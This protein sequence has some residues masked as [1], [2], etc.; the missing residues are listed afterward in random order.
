MRSGNGRHRRPRQAPALFVTA[1]VTGAGLALPLFAAGGAQAADGATWDRVAECESGGLWSANSGN[2]YY[3]GLQLTM[4]MWE[5]YGGKV[6][7]ARPDLASRGQQIEVAEKI[8]ADQGP[9]A[10]PSCS[11][12]AGLLPEG[13]GFPDVEVPEVP[14]LPDL[15]DAELP[16]VPDPEIPDVPELPDAPGDSDGSDDREDSDGG[17]DPEGSGGSDGSGGS[18]EGG[19]D[20]DDSTGGSTGGGSTGDDANGDDPSGDPP[21]GGTEPAPEESSDGT[22]GTGSGL[23]PSESEGRGDGEGAGRHRGDPGDERVDDDRSARGKHGK[24]GDAEDGY[25]VRPGDSLSAIAAEHD[26]TG[27]WPALYDGNRKTVGDDPDLILPG[28][29]L[30]LLTGGELR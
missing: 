2:G 16:D 12:G 4:E 28:Q 26:L 5:E 3:G 14:E 10:W 9:R 23:D 18:S 27:G 22:S 21:S 24:P 1:G 25:L 8:L 11:G 29:R 6:L 17:E 30:D 20:P 19:G 13:S 15:P 7:A